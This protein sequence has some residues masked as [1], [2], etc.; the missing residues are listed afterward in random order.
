VDDRSVETIFAP[1]FNIAMPDADS[2]AY[3]MI[4]GGSE[5]RYGLKE[6]VDARDVPFMEIQDEGNK[7]SLKMVFSDLGRFWHFPVETVSQSETAYELNY[8]GSCL[9]PAWRLDLLPGITKKINIDLEI[10]A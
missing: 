6:R 2:P 9:L 4:V 5:K 7:L 10:M 8:Q 3:A 1:E